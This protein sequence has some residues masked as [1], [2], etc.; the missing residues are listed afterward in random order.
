MNCE[1]KHEE[2]CARVA[3]RFQSRWL[4]SYVASKLRSDPVYGAVFALLRDSSEPVVDVGCGV[5]LLAFYL[6]ERGFEPRITG[7]DSDG[8]KISRARA[9]ARGTRDVD[10]LQQNACTEIPGTGNIVLLDLL[11]YLKPD[12]QISLL[13]R[14]G[15]SIPPGGLLVIRDCPRD[16]SLRFWLTFAAE[17]FAQSIFWNT[18]SPLH[19]PNRDALT[20]IFAA[21]DFSATVKPLWGRTPFNNH[22]FV[23]RK[24]PIATA[25]TSGARTHN[26]SPAAP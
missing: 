15:D 22:L 6:R 18:A 26:S 25:P 1:I 14:L 9:A 10:F 16:A 13:T 5:G 20:A 23:F 11:H 21:R 24:N 12:E 2:A 4:Q 19:F 17:K 3:S 7:L 8:R